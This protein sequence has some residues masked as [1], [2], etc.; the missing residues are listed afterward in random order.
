M[1]KRNNFIWKSI[2]TICWIIFIAYLLQTGTLLVNFFI[3]ILNPAATRNLHLGLDLS[4]LYYKSGFLYDLVFVTIIIISGLKAYVFYFV[5]KIFSTLNLVKPFSIEVSD[6]ISKITLFS[7]IIG[8]G[9]LVANKV[10]EKLI[11]EGYE[12]I[13]VERYWDDA[14]AYL[15][16]SAILFVIALIFKR[17]IELQNEQ[18]L[19]V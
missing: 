10:V 6:L 11:E 17:G 4:A 3:A 9:S 19:T 15:M 7:F 13:A 16:S 8:A 18:E 1:T 2:H 14:G 12:L 5:I